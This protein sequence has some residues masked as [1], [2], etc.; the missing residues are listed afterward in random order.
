MSIK[1]PNYV[2][3][4][5]NPR[6]TSRQRFVPQYELPLIQALWDGSAPGGK[7]P[8]ISCDA[9][10]PSQTHLKDIRFSTIESLAIEKKRLQSFYEKHPVTKA[11]IFAM[12]YP[13][14]TFEDMVRKIY[15]DVFG[16]SE[17]VASMK[18][19]TEIPEEEEVEGVVSDDVIDELTPLKR[20]GVAKAK[21]LAL[22]GYTSI[23]EIAQTD[24][25]ELASVKG[26]SATE[27]TEI[28]D[29]AVELS[30]GDEAEA[31]AGG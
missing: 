16:E 5:H 8:K 30:L 15:P 3:C 13:L 25:D 17:L 23:A 11:P 18:V 29:H 14:N 31:F 20:V 1:V 22:A 10:L 19:H 21:A 24:P 26:I 12:V 7:A 27:A 9:I 28:V 6:G 4:I 2:I